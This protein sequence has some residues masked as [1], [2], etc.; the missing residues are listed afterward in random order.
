MRSP[1]ITIHQLEINTANPAEL[2]Q[3]AKLCLK[4]GRIDRSLNLAY[5]AAQKDT[6]QQQLYS[7]H[8]LEAMK[9]GAELAEEIGNHHQAEHY[10]EQIIKYLPNDIEA[11]YGLAIAIANLGKY[12]EAK[13]ALERVLQLN[14]QHQKARSMLT[15]IH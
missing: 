3:A 8:Y 1:I 5:L 7:N 9:L 2:W 6:S 13:Q 11:Y 15:Q 12:P 14:P 4:L 10:W